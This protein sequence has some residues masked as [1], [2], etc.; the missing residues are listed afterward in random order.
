M[1]DQVWTLHVDLLSWD[2]KSRRSDSAVNLHIYFDSEKDMHDAFVAY[3]SAIGEH[4][5]LHDAYT[6]VAVEP[7][8]YPVTLDPP[9]D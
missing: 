2:P 5:T 1:T 7:D 3:H 6:V 8:L 4:F 9:A